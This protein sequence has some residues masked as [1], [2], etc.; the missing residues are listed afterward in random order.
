MVCDVRVDGFLL[1]C[2]SLFLG[3]AGLCWWWPSTDASCHEAWNAW[4]ARL[5]PPSERRPVGC[6]WVCLEATPRIELGMEV[7]QT[8]ALPLGYV[9]A[10]FVTGILPALLP[11]SGCTPSTLGGELEEQ[12]FRD[13]MARLAARV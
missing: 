12:E 13:V 10:P 4:C 2:C 6:I 3:W 9:A 5:S 8:S 11:A 7:L 1:A